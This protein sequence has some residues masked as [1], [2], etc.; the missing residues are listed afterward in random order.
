LAT[1]VA[2]CLA[3]TPTEESIGSG[4]DRVSRT[5][6][7][8]ALAAL[9]LELDPHAANEIADT[10]TAAATATVRMFFTLFLPQVIDMQAGC[11]RV[12]ASVERCAV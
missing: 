11:I 4:I 8:P 10:A 7:S 9:S 1:S 5:V 12:P 3:V 2:K 6:G